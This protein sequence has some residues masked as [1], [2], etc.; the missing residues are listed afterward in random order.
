MTQAEV[1]G[2]FHVHELWR[3]QD[4]PGAS[5][6]C[7]PVLCIAFFA[8]PREEKKKQKEKKDFTLGGPAAAAGPNIRASPAV[9]RYKKLI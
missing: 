3:I 4:I 5:R 7:S 6:T 8:F 9:M 2:R 1:A